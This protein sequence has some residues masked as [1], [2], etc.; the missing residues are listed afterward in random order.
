MDYFVSIAVE[1]ARKSHMS[2]KYGAVLIYRNKI[3][4][5][6]HNYDTHIST[7]NRSCLLCR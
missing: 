3:I 1:E 7:L 4:S 6:G 5:K 2:Q